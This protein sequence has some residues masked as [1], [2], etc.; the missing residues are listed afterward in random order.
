MNLGMLAK[1]AK[2][3][4]GLDPASIVALASTL[5]CDLKLRDVVSGPEL[6]AALRGQVESAAR[7]GARVVE[8][9]GRMKAGG[10]VRALLVMY[11]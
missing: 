7:S 6:S 4:S 2:G 9:E 3:G 10:V 11:S 8:V 1:L 5:G